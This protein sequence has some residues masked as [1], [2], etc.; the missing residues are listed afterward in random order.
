MSSLF[1]LA[2]RSAAMQQAALVAC[3]LVDR[4]FVDAKSP[5][6]QAWIE[7]CRRNIGRNV[8]AFTSK[9]QLIEQLSEHLSYFRISHMAA[10]APE[11]TVSVWTGE[12]LDTG[13]RARLIEGEIVVVRIVPGSPAAKAGVHLG[14]LIVAIDGAPVGQP[15]EIESWA[16]LWEVIRRDETRVQLSV[17]ADVLTDPIE[18]YFVSDRVLRVPT[19]LP[20]AYSDE[21]MERLADRVTVAD[22]MVL[23]LR[24]NHGGSF[25]A[26]LRMAG[27]FL[28]D[29]RL[30][31][32]VLGQSIG[33]EDRE[34][35][36]L[37]DP[38]YILENDLA[39]DIQLERLNR[40]GVIGLKVFSHPNCFRG[41]LAVLID[42]GTSSVAEI[43]AQALK[44]RPQTKVFGWSTAGKVV[45]ARWF[46]IE[47]LGPDYTISI[48]V[49]V[50]RSI[51]GED[52]ERKGVS[53]DETL[54][55]ELREWRSG[56]DPW[57]RSALKHLDVR[58]VSQ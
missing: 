44:D 8:D 15:E 53:P 27:L 43:F 52:L 11:E 46:S 23:D 19:F 21:A 55:D 3:D 28:C 10:F 1:F 25:P 56:T 4:E 12:A 29:S 45:M 20:D 9:T 5:Q 33:I 2:Y 51:K 13:A 57:I 40:D 34:S 38:R 31:G 35:I 17:D 26:M 24:K 37:V 50:Y 30:I 7:D 47:P 49:G 58:T 36:P 16:G 22:R 14:D 6:A 42:E 32:A 39:G 54:R 48:P 41:P 18:P